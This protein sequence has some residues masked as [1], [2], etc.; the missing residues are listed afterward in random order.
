M[1]RVKLEAGNVAYAGYTDAEY[2]PCRTC[3]TFPQP[4][5]LDGWW[6]FPDDAQ[7]GSR[8]LALPGLVPQGRVMVQT[9][10]GIIE[11]PPP[12]V[13]WRIHSQ[14]HFVCTNGHE[15]WVE[16]TRATP[17]PPPKPKP[18]ARWRTVWSEIRRRLVNAYRA[19]RGEWGDDWD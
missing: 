12:R 14:A 3:G 6:K 1:G 8:P 13:E 16:T 9:P 4:G 15:N 11:M 17:V 2:I 19:L 7:V 18:V 10:D 5:S